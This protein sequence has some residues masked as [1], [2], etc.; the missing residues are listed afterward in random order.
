MTA[1]T[2]MIKVRN[3]EEANELYKEIVKSLP[4]LRIKI[5]GFDQD[6]SKDDQDFIEEII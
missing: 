1:K 4:N 5:H 3:K 6:D 2:A